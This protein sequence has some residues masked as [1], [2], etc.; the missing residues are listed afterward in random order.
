MVGLQYLHT[1]LHAKVD[2]MMDSH[3]LL[4]VRNSLPLPRKLM[5]LQ[6]LGT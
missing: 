2:L 5:G 4:L 3:F 1:E 6:L